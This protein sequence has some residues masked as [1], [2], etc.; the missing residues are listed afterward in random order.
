MTVHQPLHVHLDC[1]ELR[2]P[3]Y[4]NGKSKACYSLLWLEGLFWPEVAL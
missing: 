3:Q 1:L 4:P 2:L